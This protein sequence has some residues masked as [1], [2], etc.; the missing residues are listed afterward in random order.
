MTVRHPDPGE[1]ESFLK[2]ELSSGENRRIVRN[3]LAAWRAYR[4]ELGQIWEERRL[5]SIFPARPVATRDYEPAFESLLPVLRTRA[6]EVARERER[7]PELVHC[8]EGWL[9]GPTA[10]APG[11]LLESHGG[12]RSWSFCEWLIEESQRLLY[13]DPGRAKELAVFA[14]TVAGSL[15]PESYGVSLIHDL[16][17]RAWAHAGRVLRVLSDLRGAEEA[18][19]TAEDLIGQGTGDALEEAGILELKAALRRDQRRPYE[20]HRLLDEAIRIYRQYRDFHL[21][22][23]A[24]VQKG[25]VYGS[26]NELEPAIR[27]LRKGL[28]LI[29]PTRERYLDLAARHSLMLYLHESGRHREARFLLKASRPELQQHGGELLNLRLRWLEG[30]IHGSLGFVDKAEEALIEARQGFIRLGVGFSAAEVSLDLAALYA[31]Q[32]RAAEMRR[33]SEEMLSIFQSRDLHREAIA[34]LITFQQAVEMERV[35]TQLLADLRSYLDRARK[36]PQLRFE[37]A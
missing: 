21:V 22:G 33:L 18:F 9:A 7:L 36:D 4:N 26:C 29:D 32:G 14:V 24:F 19:A 6:G 23:R 25:K 37:P 31:G 1:V 2:G 5:P 12:L 17:A 16:Q 8:L 13:V 30:K 35:N 20:A 34:A 15:A 28:G 10:R 27:W 11:E 3:L